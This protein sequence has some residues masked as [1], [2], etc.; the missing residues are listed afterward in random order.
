MLSI[1]IKLILIINSYNVI[2][3]HISNGWTIFMGFCMAQSCNNTLTHNLEIHN[4][5]FKSKR[6]K[7]YIKHFYFHMVAL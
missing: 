1:I 2:F 4:M 5:K 7:T 6:L 3:I